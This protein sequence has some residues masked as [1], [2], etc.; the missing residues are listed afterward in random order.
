MIRAKKDERKVKRLEGDVKK[1]QRSIRKTL[2]ELDAG[3][4]FLA[5]IDVCFAI[6]DLLLIEYVPISP[7]CNQETV[8]CREKSIEKSRRKNPH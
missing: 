1:E 6:S 2:R 5:S 7:R 8:L 3:N 4:Y